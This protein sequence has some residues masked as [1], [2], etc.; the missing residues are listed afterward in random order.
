MMYR[1]PL[2]WLIGIHIRGDSLGK[3]WEI[4][5]AVVGGVSIRRDLASDFY[6]FDSQSVNTNRNFSKGGFF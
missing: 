6:Q 1:R 2:E 4:G 5:G 3:R